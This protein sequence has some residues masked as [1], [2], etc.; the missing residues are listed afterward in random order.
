MQGFYGKLTQVGANKVIRNTFTPPNFVQIMAN[1]RRKRPRS[2]GEK[3]LLS[4]MEKDTLQSKQEE[5]CHK[6]DL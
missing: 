1:R 4:Q 2:L 5:V 6:A 3:G